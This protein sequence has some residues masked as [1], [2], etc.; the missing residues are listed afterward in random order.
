MLHVINTYK[1]WCGIYECTS[2]TSCENTPIQLYHT[3]ELELSYDLSRERG[4]L[5]FDITVYTRDSD[6][7]SL[8]FYSPK[9]QFDPNGEP[10]R[11]TYEYTHTDNKWTDLI[12]TAGR[13]ELNDYDVPSWMD[14]SY[15]EDYV[16]KYVFQKIS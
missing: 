7:K 9:E 10:L 4:G 1:E 6:G 16:E 8:M 14:K 12:V 15:A 2:F 11:F 13:I 5:E 3:V